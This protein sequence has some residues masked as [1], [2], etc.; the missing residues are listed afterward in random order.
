MIAS[1]FFFCA[2]LDEKSD[3]HALTDVEDVFIWAAVRSRLFFQR[4]AVQVEDIDVVESVH[5]ALAHAAKGGVV[6]VA[7]VG[8]HTDDAPPGL[9]NFPLGKTEEFDVVVLK[10]FRIFLTQRLAIYLFVSADQFAFHH[11]AI[12][13]F[14]D[15]QAPVL[16]EC[17]E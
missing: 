11:L 8:D 7:V 5:Q 12:N 6:E 14:S 13:Q 15:I 3:C 1:R 2:A 16:L 4:I 10:P 9:L 17:P